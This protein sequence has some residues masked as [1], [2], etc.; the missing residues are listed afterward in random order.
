[1]V[2][3]VTSSNMATS[4]SAHLANLQSLYQSGY[5]PQQV[6]SFNYGDHL[7]PNELASFKSTTQPGSKVPNLNDL[8]SQTYQFDPNKYLPQINQTASSIYDPQ[9]A[10]I[11]ALQQ[12]QTSQ[13]EQAT[14]KT[15]EQFAKTLEAEI[16]SINARGAFFGGGALNREADIRKQENYALTDINLQNQAAQ[17][18][19]LAQQAGLSSAQAEYI[20]QKLS[21]AENSE[22]SRFVDQRNY[23]LNL[24][25]QQQEEIAN[26]MRL[27][28]DLAQMRA[29]EKAA[30]KKK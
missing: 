14:V 24:Y 26:A 4:E 13:P 21:G 25:Q 5:T 20:Q 12:L 17:A 19:M 29:A 3:G 6:A 8:T 1:M 15:K 18:G 22:Y 27:Q 11:Q 2:L 7:N 23:S 9:R 30:K 10:Q 28:T 16:E